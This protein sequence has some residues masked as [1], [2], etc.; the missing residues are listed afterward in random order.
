M[1]WFS[2]C[3]LVILILSSHIVKDNILDS[4]CIMYVNRLKCLVVGHDP[5]DACV[6]NVAATLLPLLQVDRA[7]PTMPHPLALP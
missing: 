6:N 1:P 2:Y 4:K 3:V 5:R 7:S